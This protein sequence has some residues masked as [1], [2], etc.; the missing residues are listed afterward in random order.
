MIRVVIADDHTMVRHGLRRVLSSEP[1]IHIVAEAANGQQVLDVVKADHVDVVVLD[2]T[3]PGRNGLEILKELRKSFPK[4]AV[5]MLSM[6]PKD[7]YGV[8]VIK[9][10]AAAYISKE[11]APEELVNALRIAARGEKYITPDLAELLARHLERGLVTEEPHKLLSDREYEVMCHIAAGRGLTEIAKLMNLSVKTVSTYR[12]R[13]VEKTGLTS[14]A[15]MTRYAMQ[16]SL[17]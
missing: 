4:V 9:A 11:S 17:M 10:G 12:T 15:D 8:R 16:H 1:D 3:M 7:Q 13:I 2:I 14:N 6:H 5:I